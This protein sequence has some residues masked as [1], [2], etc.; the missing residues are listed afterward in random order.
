MTEIPSSSEPRTLPSSDLTPVI[1]LG[2]LPTTLVSAAR[3]PSTEKPGLNM[4]TM[5]FYP[6]ISIESDIRIC[7]P[8]PNNA[9]WL[10][11]SV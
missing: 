11:L 7:S 6:I 1:T 10:H 9:V 8:Y 2:Y 5:S 4:M 3:D